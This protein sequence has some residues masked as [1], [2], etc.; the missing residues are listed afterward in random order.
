M[1]PVP[2]AGGSSE[3]LL[4]AGF[5]ALTVA[6]CGAGDPRDTTRLRVGLRFDYPTPNELIAPATLSYAAVNAQ[7]FLPLFAERP[8]FR[9][10]PP[11][12]A[13]GLASAWELS[14]DRLELTVRLRP[15]A[16]WSDGEPVTAE[17][18]RFTFEAQ[19]STDVLWDYS[20]VKASIVDV[21]VVDAETVRFHFGA[22]RPSA[23]A[24]VAT[25]AILPRHAWAELPFADWRGEPGW[26]FDRLVTNGPF[27]LESRTPGREL[28][29]ARNPDHFE[30]GLPRLEQISLRSANDGAVLT[31]QLLAGELDAVFG[32]SVVDAE[33]LERR[34]GVRLIAYE[35]RQFTFVTWNTTKPQFADPGTRR[36]L[37][38][39]IDRQTIVD[40]V[41]RGYARVG[42]SPIISGVWARDPTLEPWPHDPGA[43]RTALAEAGWRDTDADGVLDRGGEPFRFE[44]ATYTGGG[45]RWEALQMIQADLRSVGIDAQPRRYDPN[46]LTARL[47]G[48]DF[49]AASST[50]AIDTSLDLRF[51]FHSESIGGGHNYAAYANPEVDLL[52]DGFSARLDPAGG[53][54]DL[55]R[56]Q[57]ILHRDQPMLVLWESSSLAAADEALDPVTPNALS[58][59]ADLERWAWR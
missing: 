18:V 38:L 28:V 6:A 17:D 47:I 45:A 15:D 32:I 4:V 44:L 2:V 23:L 56:L 22:V 29:L 5:A 40:T 26:F 30:E 43:A 37:A 55:H 33:R 53:L 52:L 51:A 3:R 21:E 31:N 58:P 41:W 1:I 19:T 24:D 49:D 16:R 35:N 12:F 25:G 27:R 20:F 54:E 14:D 57:R 42:V 34:P 10:G 50:F 9:D 13:P 39:A 46:V 7:M 48:Q 36:A 11:T 8:D 59:L